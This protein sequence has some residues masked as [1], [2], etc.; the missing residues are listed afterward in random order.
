MSADTQA[1]N[2]TMPCPLSPAVW[3]RLREPVS[4]S[5]KEMVQ[6]EAQLLHH[7][8]QAECHLAHGHPA[9]AKMSLSSATDR[10]DLLVRYSTLPGSV[11]RYAQQIV[12][13]WESIP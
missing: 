12:T 2:P 6:V 9:S 11:A 5:L 7:I 1:R 8:K 3:L 10:W 4:L 13:L